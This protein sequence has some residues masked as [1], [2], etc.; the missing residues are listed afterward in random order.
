M[1]DSSTEARARWAEALVAYHFVD[2]TLLAQ[3]LSKAFQATGKLISAPTIQNLMLQ[4]ISAT[5]LQGWHQE[6]CGNHYV[7]V[8]LF[9][10]R[11]GKWV[12]SL[13]EALGLTCV[14]LDVEDSWADDSMPEVQAILFGL[15]DRLAAD[16]PE[17]KK[18]L[19]I[20]NLVV[21]LQSVH[22]SKR[23]G[24]APEQTHV[25]AQRAIHGLR[26]VR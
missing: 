14:D 26:L 12:S 4:R 21:A 6:I 20:S 9:L 25:R 13:G 11:Y 8:T 22:L 3:E 24:D 1:L 18:I 5:L 17:A 7:G 2:L 23:R 19:D 10:R 16:F 15:T